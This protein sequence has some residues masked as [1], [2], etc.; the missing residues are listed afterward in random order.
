MERNEFL[1]REFTNTLR[2]VAIL[3]I[4]A[5]HIGAGGYHCRIFTPLGGIGVAMFLFLSG[6]GLTESYK[7]N[8]LAHFWRK[9]ALRILIPYAVWLLVYH[10]V[11]T[12]SPLTPPSLKPLF[13]PRYWFVE[14]LAL[15]Y[16]LFYVLWRWSTQHVLVLMGVAAVFMFFLMP[17]NTQ[18]EQSLSFLLGVLVSVRKEQF[19]QVRS[20]R[21]C[22]TAVC[23]LTVG[24][25]AL[26]VKQVPEFRSLGED[27]LPMRCVQL[28]LK[29]PIAAAMMIFLSLLRVRGVQPLVFIG[30]M[31]FELYLVHM[32]FYG[33]IDGNSLNMLLFLVQSFVLAYLVFW[34]DKRITT[35]F[36]SC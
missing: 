30:V 32:P 4:M 36:R 33:G 3:L 19:R 35:I 12:L 18:S 34:C 28:L 20:N 15:W 25:T 26:A 2:G 10:L 24:L 29:F 1:N 22:L 17:S 14:Y 31:S 5:G 11:F 8:G 7:T 16:L 13:L 6:Y 9:K 23:L 21:F 27:S